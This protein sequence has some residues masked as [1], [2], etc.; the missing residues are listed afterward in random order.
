MGAIYTGKALVIRQP[1]AD[2]VVDGIKG[3][4]NRS[5]TT[6]YRGPL[7]IVAGA[8]R[9]KKAHEQAERIARQVGLDTF[10][11]AT[12]YGAVVGFVDLVAIT[13]DLES[14][15]AEPGAHHWLLARPRRLNTPK[16]IKGRLG[17]FDIS[18]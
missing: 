9:D 10:T 8:A 2:L 3:V 13:T 1:W 4:E 16:P 15:W 7:A 12:V 14:P 11:P 17:L 18:I 5:W 6:A